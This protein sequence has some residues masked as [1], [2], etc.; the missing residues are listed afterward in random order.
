MPCVCHVIKDHNAAEYSGHTRNLTRL[1]GASR[2]KKTITQRGI[3]TLKHALS[4][5]RD[6]VC[7]RRRNKRSS[8]STR[9]VLWVF[10]SYVFALLF[11][12]ERVSKKRSPW[13]KWTYLVP[14]QLLLQKKKKKGRQSDRIRNSISYEIA[15]VFRYQSVHSGPL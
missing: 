7:D 11:A 14:L 13:Q 12:G 2:V 9:A 5:R 6:T 10:I 8:S 1:I 4:Y 3:D 15:F